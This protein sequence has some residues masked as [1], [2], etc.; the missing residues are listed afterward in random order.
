VNRESSRLSGQDGFHDWS[1]PLR[2]VLAHAQSSPAGLSSDEAHRRLTQ[3]GPNALTVER[4]ASALRTF[5]S[6]FKNPVVLILI[7]AAL[8]SAFMAEWADAAV[9]LV[10]VMGS[11]VLSFSQEYA[12]SAAVARLRERVR[13]SSTVLRDGRP[14]QIPSEEVVPG[15]VVLLSAGNVI[16]A[17]GRVLE[18]KDFLVN[19]AALTG[20]TYPAEKRA[21]LASDTASLSERD[22]CVFAGTHA[23]SGTARALIVQTGAATA[24][25][26]IAARLNASPSETD[27]QRGIRHFGYLLTQIMLLLTFAVFAINVF[28]ARPAIESLLFAMALAVGI[29]PELLPAIIS[30]NLSKGAQ[31]MAKHGVIVRRLDAIEDLGSMDTLCTD[32]TGTLTAGVIKLDA[33]LDKKGEP[34]QDVLRLAAL[35]ARLQ[36]GLRNPLDEAIIAST[37]LDVG[38]VT[39]VDEVPYDFARRRLSVIVDQPSQPRTMITKGA[40]ESVLGVCDG[41]DP[42]M[43]AGIDLQ[44]DAWS[45]TGFR[46]LGV[47]TKALDANAAQHAF[48]A[49]DERAMRFA[50]F[51]L[52]FDPPKP[53][54]QTTVRDLASLG[55]QLKVITGDNRRVAKHLAEVIGVPI[56]AVLTGAEIGAMRDEQLLHAAD[57]AALFAEVDPNQKERIINA[58]KRAGRVVG[59]LGDGINDAPALRAADVGVS[60]D[61]AVDVAKEAADFVLLEHDLDVLRQGIEQGRVTFANTLKYIFTTTSANFGNMFS[62]AGATLFLPFLP[63][64][65]GQILLNN[66]LSDFPA[67][68]IASD[69]VD[70]DWVQAPHRWNITFIRNFMV[71]FGLV[72]SLFDYMTFGVLLWVLRSSPAQFRT[73][74]FIESLLTE[75]IVALVVRTRR[76]FFR[77]RPGKWLLLSSLLVAVIT[78][79]IPY[80]PALG[81]LFG[82]VPLPAWVMALLAGITLLYIATV[83][84]TK[85]F[86]FKRYRM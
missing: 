77:S 83:E 63:L 34:S 39:L 75:L 15:D 24:F 6:Q 25:G 3:F 45:E 13:I 47:A 79:A 20:E 82:F 52:F 59:Y 12:A 2:D 7:F 61:S 80:L 1:Q 56:K 62:M 64:T 85:H 30:I 21:G 4:D 70:E 44:F 23:Q 42:S 10:I 58:L 11:A 5:V 36:T 9:I 26:Q 55:V 38:G 41:I 86:F 72:S 74:W 78:A 76:P 49:K 40:L 33:A 65:A 60:V 16:P 46:V 19:Q 54:V 22:N 14:Q 81:E 27:F 71:V 32:K 84:I 31:R 48:S 67:I 37:N 69:N 29:S 68:T 43:H 50:G 8:V 18:A 66:F 53:D 57:R 17:D 28:F 51:L 73:G 35:N